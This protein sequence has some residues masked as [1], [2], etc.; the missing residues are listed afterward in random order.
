MC[1]CVC[2]CVC[3]FN[4]QEAKLQAVEQERDRAVQSVRQH[5]V[6]SVDDEEEEQG[7]N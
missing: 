1:V 3:V 4:V 2:V 7:E 6:H 5:V